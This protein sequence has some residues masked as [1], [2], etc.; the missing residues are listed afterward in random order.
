MSSPSK[1]QRPSVNG[2]LV[3]KAGFCRPSQRPS[4]DLQLPAVKTDIL[5]SPSGV[6]DAH[7]KFDVDAQMRHIQLASLCLRGFLLFRCGWC[8]FSSCDCIATARPR[9][10]AFL[11]LLSPDDG[12]AA[13][14]FVCFSCH[15]A[16]GLAIIPHVLVVMVEVVA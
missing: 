7:R 10:A 4:S 13:T 15:S 1:P 16:K 14:Q 12:D 5:Q 8:C 3:R 2:P 6:G 9:Q 11:K